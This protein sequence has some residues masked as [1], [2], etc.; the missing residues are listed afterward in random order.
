MCRGGARRRRG[1]HGAV[2]SRQGPA[3]PAIHPERPPQKCGGGH[4]SWPRSGAQ[5]PHHDFARI[6]SGTCAP[7]CARGAA[8]AARPGPLGRGR[9]A[10]AGPR[11]AACRPAYPGGRSAGRSLR[12]AKGGGSR[13]AAL[14]GGREAHAATGHTGPRGWGVPDRTGG[15]SAA[16]RF[17]APLSPRACPPGTPPPRT[18]ARAPSAPAAGRRPFRRAR[19]S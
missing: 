14:Q 3:A 17:R 2:Y 10:R 11:R 4:C 5:A 18:A 8:R 19:P 6:G 9:G 1:K 15:G 12:Q 13:R 7:N 16:A